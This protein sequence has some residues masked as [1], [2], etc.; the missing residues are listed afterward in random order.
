[1]DNYLRKKEVAQPSLLAVIV[2][3]NWEYPRNGCRE[4]KKK[5]KIEDHLRKEKQKI[6]ALVF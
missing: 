1:M 2:G 6:K 3:W 5:E 4:E